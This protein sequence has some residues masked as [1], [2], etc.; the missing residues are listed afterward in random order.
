[1]LGAI[2][3]SRFSDHGARVGLSKASVT[4]EE[5]L[6]RLRVLLDQLAA[7][8][9]GD[10]VGLAQPPPAA[11]GSSFEGFEWAGDEAET[12][13][14]QA[15]LA[16]LAAGDDGALGPDDIDAFEAIVLL[17]NRP[18]CFVERGRYADFA[19][20]WQHLNAAAVRQALAPVVAAV[21]RIEL[22]DHPVL[23]YVGTGFVAGPGLVM[24]NRHVAELLCQGLGTRLIYRPGAAGIHFGRER[25]T[26]DDR[27]PR[28]VTSAV[29][30][31]PYWDMALLRVDGLA[32]APLALAAIAGE[33]VVDRD[34]VVIGYPARDPRNDLVEQDRIFARTYNV[35]CVQPGK[36]R[37][38]R[39][40]WSFGAEV[41]AQVHDAST[42]GGNSGSAVVDVATGQVVGL[43]FRG[44]YLVANYAVPMYELARDP[45]VV[46]A[47]VQFIGE[48]VGRDP[49][50][51]AAWLR[52][53]QGEAS[54]I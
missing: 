37:A 12:A 7:D 5:K 23:P 10:L 35:K 14:A 53:T 26:H 17:R 54:R 20:P 9:G 29:M 44:R 1:M 24:T 21:G 32:T 41:P 4:R 45:R 39:P 33:E 6:R 40:A 52:A 31:H 22:A 47:G 50:V 18:V 42:L 38:A 27:D 34:V 3:D 46:D 11:P 36:L 25:N 13:R 30:V 48:P 8:R 51:E 2:F 43:H 19:A 49:S 15:A 28:A 16:K